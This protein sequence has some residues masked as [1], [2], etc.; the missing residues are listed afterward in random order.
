MRSPKDLN[1]CRL[2]NRSALVCSDRVKWKSS[3]PINGCSSQADVKVW[4]QFA[5][6]YRLNE[7]M[8]LH[9]NHRLGIGRALITKLIGCGA[10]VIAVDCRAQDLRQLE[11]EVS[12]QSFLDS[13]QFLSIIS[14]IKS[15]VINN[16]YYYI[17]F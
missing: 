17:F 11:T 8:I 16:S 14:L 15:F 4:P 5:S 2:C 1:R 6:I 9:L 10:Y 12:V 13:I 3:S 7:L